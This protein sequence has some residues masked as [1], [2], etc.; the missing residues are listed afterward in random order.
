MIAMLPMAVLLGCAASE[1]RFKGEDG[2]VHSSH[3]SNP[4]PEFRKHFMGCLHETKGAYG[5]QGLGVV[6]N[7]PR[8]M[9]ICMGRHGYVPAK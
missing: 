2:R 3:R 4:D 9:Q 7:L 1:M 8:D 5:N 6:L